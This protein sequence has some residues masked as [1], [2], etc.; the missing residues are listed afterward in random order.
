MQVAVSGPKRKFILI[1]IIL[2]L[3]FAFNCFNRNRPIGL[4]GYYLS[5]FPENSKYYLYKGLLSQKIGTGVI[6]ATVKKLYYT[7][8]NILVL[9]E[10][11]IIEKDQKNKFIR[12]EIWVLINLYTERQ[13]YARN[14][15]ELN[16]DLSNFKQ[17]KIF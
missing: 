9:G 6:D 4:T 2:L 8:K 11:T 3:L 7:E 10:S 15:E 14:L 13:K 17:L 5:Y 1:G 12:N 16:L